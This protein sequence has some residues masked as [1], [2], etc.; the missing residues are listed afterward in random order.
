[1]FAT[2]V[3]L[4]AELAP[5]MSRAFVKE[6]DRDDETL[7]DREV[8]THPNFVTARG[9]ARLEARVRELEQERSAARAVG[10]SGTVARAARELRYYQVRRDSARLIEP[11]VSP[12][13]VRFGVQVHLDCG[14][15]SQ[16]SYR[17]VGEDESDP[18][19]GL[20][21]YV[22]PLARELIGLETG[23]E[24]RIGELTAV[25]CRLET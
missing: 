3:G 16:R 24:V 2:L 4:T 5:F 19:C 20:L 25:V 15:G 10:D 22:S 11:A 12:R 1:M 8:S 18:A 23:D 17:I 21:S 14:D 6:S 7:P 9:L 13:V